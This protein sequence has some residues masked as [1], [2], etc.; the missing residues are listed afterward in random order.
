MHSRLKVAPAAL[1]LVFT[2]LV[3][4]GGV[5]FAGANDRAI[6][7]NDVATLYRSSVVIKNAR[8]HIATF[9]A[10]QVK[11]SFDYN[12]ENCQLAA[13]LFQSQQGVKTRFWCEKGFYEK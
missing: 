6:P 2:L 11:N 8:F 12:W 7:Q 9:D 5:S 10:V 3:T 4:S 1:M 13:G